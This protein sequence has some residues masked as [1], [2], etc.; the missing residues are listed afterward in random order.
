MV[1][2]FMMFMFFVALA[3]LSTSVVLTKNKRV[4][5]LETFGKFSGTRE[6]GISFKL[7]YP[8]Q[9]VAKVLALHIQEIKMDLELKTSDNLFIR[10]PV[11]VQVR[12]VDAQKACYELEDATKQ[13]MSYISNLI[14]SEVGK[15]SFLEL[16]SVRN[17]IQDEVQVVLAEKMKSFGYEIVDVLVNEPIPTE[18]VQNSYNSVTASE[19]QRDAAKNIAEAKRI[20]MIAEAEAHKESKKLQGE[21]IAAQRAA[22][23]HGFKEATEEIASSLGI[24]S[25]MAVMMILQLNKFDTIRDASNG[26]GTVI[27]TDGSSSSEIT[28]MAR[29]TAA[30]KNTSLSKT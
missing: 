15:R 14:R 5:V 3:Y 9:S 20:G 8:F 30:F 24:S 25:E 2:L 18:D 12:V 13:I 29:M 10:Y 27:I 23:A 28:E 16:Y 17:E 4:S 26:H 11:I 21:G 22:I 1:E 6:A 7:P 19:R